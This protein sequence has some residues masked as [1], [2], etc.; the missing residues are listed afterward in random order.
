MIRRYA[1]IL[2]LFFI[3]VLQGAL[4][5]EL[6]FGDASPNLLLLVALAW[7]LLAGYEDGLVW[8]FVAGIYMDLI[9]G[10]PT[11]VSAMGMV[12]CIFALNALMGNV[13]RGNLLLPPAVAAL[14]TVIYYSVVMVLLRLVGRDVNF[15]YTL[16]R[17]ALPSAL[18]NLVFSFLVFNIVARVWDL[19]RPRRVQG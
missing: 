14:S 5:P 6:R 16:T 11:G 15:T 8:A 12:V 3:A 10:T 9:S 13:Q 17:I 19:Y 1:S 2:V 18:Y 4:V 7:G